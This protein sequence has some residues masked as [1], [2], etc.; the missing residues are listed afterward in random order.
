MSHFSELGYIRVLS[1]EN[2]LQLIDL[3]RFPLDRAI[4]PDGKTLWCQFGK[5]GLL[6]RAFSLGR[7]FFGAPSSLERFSTG[8]HHPIG[9]KFH[10]AQTTAAHVANA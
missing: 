5:P 6:G 8:W 3:E 9:S 7:Q 4:P 10:P 1:D 2:M